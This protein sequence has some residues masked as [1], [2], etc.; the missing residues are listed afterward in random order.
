MPYSDSC[1]NAQYHFH[2][3]NTCCQFQFK[4][5]SKT[6]PYSRSFHCATVSCR[7]ETVA[8]TLN[9]ISI[10]TPLAVSFN[11]IKNQRPCRTAVAFTVLLSHAVQWQLLWRSILFPS[12]HNLLW[13][14]IETQLKDL[15][16]QLLLW[17]FSCLMPYSDS[18]CNNQYHYHLNNP[19][20]QFQ[21]KPNSKTLAYGRF[22]HCSPV[23]CSRVKVA[24]KFNTISIYTPLAVSFNSNPNL[25]IYRTAVP[26]TVPL[27]HAVQW[28]LL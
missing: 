25:I 26:F 14:S 22:F 5:N 12:T 13:V 27:S 2:L 9:N 20:C 16:V 1:C 11:S 10:Y 21:F 19:C 18:C 3:H 8:V 17:L 23:L 6:L 15:T 4:P 7:R 28:Q 24:V